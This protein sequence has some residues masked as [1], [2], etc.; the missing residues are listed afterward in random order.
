MLDA[1]L[2]G[3]DDPRPDSTVDQ[4][5]VHSATGPCLDTVNR[6]AAGPAL[7]TA[8]VT[9]S[10]P[11]ATSRNA[12][13]K[14]SPTL[15]WSRILHCFGEQDLRDTT[16]RPSGAGT[17]VAAPAERTRSPASARE[18]AA[19]ASAD[20]ALQHDVPDG[21]GDLS[22]DDA[23]RAMEV[24]SASEELPFRSLYRRAKVKWARRRLEKQVRKLI[25][26][27]SNQLSN[28]QHVRSGQ[29][30]DAEFAILARIYTNT[31]CEDFQRFGRQESHALAEHMPLFL[32]Y[33][34]HS[35]PLDTPF[36]SMSGQNSW[37]QVA[38][39]T[40]ERI[41]RHQNTRQLIETHLLRRCAESV[42][43]ALFMY[44]Y[45]DGC[46]QIGPA[47]DQK[48]TLRIIV[49]IENIMTKSVRATVPSNQVAAS[50]LS[51]PRARTM[52]LQGH[53]R[54]PLDD[55]VTMGASERNTS[56]RERDDQS[57]YSPR[58]SG[59]T[60]TTPT[61]M[62]QMFVNARAD[63]PDHLIKQGLSIQESVAET[64]GTTNKRHAT[65]M[66]MDRG[67]ATRASCEPG[68][69]FE[70]FSVTIDPG[71]QGELTE[72]AA[73][74]DVSIVC[75]RRGSL[76]HAQL[77]FTRSLVS[78]SEQALGMSRTQRMRFVVRELA[79]LNTLLESERRSV[80]LPTERVAH[81]VLR[82]HANETIVFSTK[83]HAPYLTVAEVQDFE[84]TEGGERERRRTIV[85]RV[86][87][88]E[89]RQATPWFGSPKDPDTGHL[90]DQTVSPSPVYARGDETGIVNLAV[91]GASS[92]AAVSSTVSPPSEKR[93]PRT[94][95]A[96]IG[97]SSRLR[98]LSGTGKADHSLTF[99]GPNQAEAPFPFATSSQIDTKGTEVTPA[100]TP[101]R[102]IHA[103]TLAVNLRPFD[104]PHD[105]TQT[106]IPT[107]DCPG[108]STPSDER[109]SSTSGRSLPTTSTSGDRWSRLFGEYWTNKVQRIQRDS[110]FG[111]LPGWRLTSVIVKSKDQL[112]QE[113][114][115]TILIAEFA[116]I[117][118][119][120][121][122]PVW[123][124]P[125]R[126]VATGADSGFVQVI[127]DAYSID[128]IKKAFHGNI[129]LAGYFSERFGPRG[130]PSHR[131]AVRNFVMSMAGY[132]VVTY[133]LNIKDRHNGNLLIDAEGHIIHIDFGFLF[134][135]SPGGNIEFE[136]S[137]FKLTWELAD[138]MGG[139]DSNAFRWFRRLCG[140]AYAEACAHRNK[141]MLMVEFMM[142][143]NE[144]LPCFRGGPDLTLEQ[145]RERFM[146]RQTRLKRIAHMNA[147][148]DRS[149]N[150]WTTRFYDRYQRC[151]TGI[152]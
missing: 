42:R 38:S 1:S 124:R 141:I 105:E 114:F 28:L 134:T 68:S 74:R 151:C 102:K 50:I 136:K 126:I 79:R 29:K 111:M 118:E 15:F 89:Q 44:W 110:P 133:L 131:T 96:V 43:F 137:P 145:L 27:T 45:L 36:T 139:P 113:M 13:A 20:T 146:P 78:I 21:D 11:A 66:N 147:L 135:N 18:A 34:L 6:D 24:S 47:S 87:H 122:L 125:Y 116:R 86:V 109:P 33:L 93:T 16:A 129:T 127:P 60:R 67:N 130:S 76:F 120:V 3:S 83:E 25:E 12:D 5:P 62:T 82:I 143:G 51:E 7:T 40:R 84:P 63:S 14:V 80:F 64:P 30:L 17:S 52:P 132:S 101:N 58:R 77:D 91:S 39:S 61:P 138:V 148:V 88:S 112:R 119:A 97:R 35:R 95:P 99:L 100:D 142:M 106:R 26:F 19:G 150:H 54:K 94:Q 98:H 128:Q 53:E 115:A 31:R 2:L 49:E 144:S 8:S 48:D 103:Q 107:Q 121:R 46:V 90:P 104:D 56:A 72:T 55:S 108:E 57:G 123:L 85:S 75:A 149:T 70:E 140:Q 22:G 9:K 10:T 4:E 117:F 81:R 65:D 37:R 59:V 73:E 92:G 71:P 32:N 41:R 152:Y 23:E 69:P